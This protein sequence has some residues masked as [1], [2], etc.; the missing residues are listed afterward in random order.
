MPQPQDTVWMECT[1]RSLPFGVLG[2]FTENRKAM[3]ITD[4]GGVLINT[5]IS[6]FTDNI[7]STKTIIEVLANG[8]AQVRAHIVS[9]GDPRDDLLNMAHDMQEDEK[10]KFFMNYY[11]WKQ[12][13]I[14]N[15][16]HADRSE[17]PYWLDANM[18]YE[19]IYSFKAGNKYFLDNRLYPIFDEEIPETATRA[20]DYYFDFPYQVM[21]TTVF[22]LGNF[23][24]METLPK[25]KIISKNFADYVSAYNWDAATGNLTIIARLQVKQMVIKAADYAA[26]LDF[27]KQ[28]MADVN[29]KIIIRKN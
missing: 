20:N 23:F 15:I 6:N 4:Q 5:P 27:K 7:Q 29:E 17:N 10:K 1:S 19:K 28:V 16:T 3:M 8:D 18:E 22:K 13:D 11:H 14:M 2:P 12:P 26:L 9:E 25:P 24:T 21:D